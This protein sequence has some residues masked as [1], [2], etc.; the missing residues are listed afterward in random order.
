MTSRYHQKLCF[1][2][3]SL[4]SICS[5]ARQLAAPRLGRRRVAGDCGDEFGRVD[6][7][8]IFFGRVDVDGDRLRREAASRRPGGPDFVDA[9]FVELERPRCRVTR[10]PDG[11]TTTQFARDFGQRLHV[12]NLA[13]RLPRVRRFELRE[14]LRQLR[15]RAAGT[16]A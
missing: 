11:V 16:R 13:D 7:R 6:R 1:F 2:S 8:Q 15:A 14:V 3:A 9:L 5:A 10:L 12:D 4:M